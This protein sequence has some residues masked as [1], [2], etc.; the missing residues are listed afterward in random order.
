VLFAPPPWAGARSPALLSRMT[1]TSRL[2]LHLL[3]RWDR[4]ELCCRLVPVSHWI[5]AWGAR[6]ATPASRRPWRHRAGEELWWQRRWV[7]SRGAVGCPFLDQR[8]RLEDTPSRGKFHKESLPFYLLE[9]VVLG[10]LSEVRF[11][12]LKTYF[13]SVN[14][15]YVFWYLQFCH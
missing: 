5:V 11:F 4:L 8:P 9:P 7:F 15:K 2:R 14:Q 3:V 12:V 6:L 1:I 13:F 10:V